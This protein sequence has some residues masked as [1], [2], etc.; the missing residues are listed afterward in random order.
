MTLFFKIESRKI[1][2]NGRNTKDINIEIGVI[3]IALMVATIL[4]LAI[5]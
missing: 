5:K 2:K 4:T 1:N 3:P